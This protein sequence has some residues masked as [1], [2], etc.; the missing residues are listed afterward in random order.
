MNS[1]KHLNLEERETLRVG[2]ELRKS[3]RNIAKE[4]GRSHTSLSREWK[5]N[6]MKKGK[7]EGTYIACRADAKAKKRIK[8]QRTK[9]PLK[10]PFIFLYVRQHLRKGWSPEIIAGRLSLVHPEY[11]IH[12]ETIYRYIYSKSVK[13]RYKLWQFLRMRRKKR[14]E[15]KG[16][17]VRK[18]QGKIPNTISI[19]LRPEAA[20]QRTEVGH[21]ETDNMEGKKSEKK[22]LSVTVDR[23]LRYTLLKLMV[24][25]KAESKIEAIIDGLSPLDGSLKKT[26]T[27]DNGKENSQH[28]QI[29]QE[30]NMD[31]FFCHAYHSWEKGSVENTVGRIRWYLPKKEGL[32]HVT[33]EL[34]TWIQ[35]QLNYMPR[36]CLGFKT[37]HEVMVEELTKSQS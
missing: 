17:Q 33:P 19:D 31:G 13:N 5:R 16:R 26:I 36:K 14:R 22:A 28:E 20:N 23:K 27:Y 3:F 2:R 18:Y 34:V 4:L 24:D 30:L 35:D 21:W 29:R 10:C 12:H 15:K 1:Y 32:A 25:Q 6:K 37:P 9:A 11:S 7:D 8:D